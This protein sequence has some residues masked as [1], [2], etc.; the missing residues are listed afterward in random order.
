[1]GWKA[2]ENEGEI[3]PNADTSVVQ[4]EDEGRWGSIVWGKESVDRR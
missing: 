2:R 1:M 3:W 4:E